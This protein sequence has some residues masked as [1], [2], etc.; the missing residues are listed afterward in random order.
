[1]G[2]KTKATE[3]KRLKKKTKEGKVRKRNLRNK[4]TTKTNKVLFGD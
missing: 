3:M 2:S 4:G 1:M